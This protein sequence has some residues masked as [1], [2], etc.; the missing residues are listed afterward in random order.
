MKKQVLKARG[1]A[2][3][4]L[5]F[6]ISISS[7]T[8]MSWGLNGVVSQK[9]IQR[10]VTQENRHNLI[11]EQVVTK[12]LTDLL[13]ATKHPDAVALKNPPQPP[14]IAGNLV[15]CASIDPDD[16]NRNTL[17]AYLVPSNLTCQTPHPGNYQT[18]YPTTNVLVKQVTYPKGVFRVL[19]FR[20]NAN[21]GTTFLTPESDP[22]VTI[23]KIAAERYH[24][25]ITFAVCT[26]PVDGRNPPDPNDPINIAAVSS[27]LNVPWNPTCALDTQANLT[28]EGFIYTNTPYFQN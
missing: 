26:D 22:Q 2:M 21:L 12:I 15:R 8:L 9:N 4:L 11:L 10:R 16:G 27:T 18:F 1:A 25:T 17:D 19:Y 14:I 6:A 3:I 24:I 23:R 13:L 7:L 28:Y 20:K 5:S